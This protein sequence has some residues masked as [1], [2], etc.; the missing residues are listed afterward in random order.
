[1]PVSCA[2]H[3]IKNVRPCDVLPGRLP[4]LLQAAVRAVAEPAFRL[5]WKI[6]E[7]LDPLHDVAVVAPCN[8]IP[9]ALRCDLRADALTDDALAPEVIGTAI[10]SDAVRDHVRVEVIG[11]FMRGKDVLVIVH[12]DRFQETLHVADDLLARWVF[13][14]RVGNDEMIDWIAAA[15]REYRHRFHLDRRRFNRRHAAQ[16]NPCRFLRRACVRDATLEGGACGRDGALVRVL[17]NV[18]D[19][20]GEGPSVGTRRDG[21]RNHAANSRM[22]VTT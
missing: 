6:V 17:G 1:M 21:L 8:D 22:A 5:R 16:V 12:S 14:F 9:P 10:R 20:D 11:V 7:A 3:G 19:A 4:A 2:I 18:V 15:R 13:V